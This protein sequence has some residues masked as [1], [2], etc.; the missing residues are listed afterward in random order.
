MAPGA[1]AALL[2]VSCLGGC[3]SKAARTPA[4]ITEAEVA[5]YRFGLD[6]ECRAAGRLRGETPASIVQFCDCVYETL[7]HNARGEEWRRLVHL[8]DNGQA[9]EERR[10]LAP[11]TV[12]V[13][14]CRDKPLA[15]TAASAASAS[16]GA[17]LVGLWA[18]K[19]PF[20]GC[21]EAFEFRDN[22]TVRIERGHER[23][24]NT[25]VVAAAPEASGRYKV[26]L[27]ATLLASG[28]TCDGT[29]RDEEERNAP[30]FILFGYRNEALAV[31]DSAEG[32]D[33]TGPLQR[34]H[35]QH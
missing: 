31:C 16:P 32:A 1:A 35:E 15:Q 7:Q 10:A 34:Q 12:G 5:R 30:L 24:E 25:Y 27:A 20:D 28:L 22:G 2:L 26:S 6:Q 14:A 17:A 23:T 21:R 29:F 33:C 18:W 3:A 4:D 19:R 13:A 11:L 9:D 8:N